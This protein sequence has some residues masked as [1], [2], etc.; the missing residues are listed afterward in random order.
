MGFAQSL[1]GFSAKFK[2]N[3]AATREGVDAE[4]FRSIVEGS[5]ITGAPGQ[6]VK[7]RKLHDSWTQDVADTETVTSSDSPYATAVE[8]NLNNAVYEN[9]GPHSVKQTVVAFP[10]IVEDVVR[11]IVG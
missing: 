8:E 7:T 6:P 5:E 1:S 2:A 11:G 9:H 3:L 10:R 4:T